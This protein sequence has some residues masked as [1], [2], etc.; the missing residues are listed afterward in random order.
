MLTVAR[1]MV[2]MNGHVTLNQVVM[3]ELGGSVNEKQSVLRLGHDL[4]WWIQGK[5]LVKQLNTRWYTLLNTDDED[6]TDLAMRGV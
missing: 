6:G 4:G 2:H 1:A 5:A 3:E